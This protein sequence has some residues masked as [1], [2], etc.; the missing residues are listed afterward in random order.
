MKGVNHE[1]GV[2]ADWLDKRL[3]TTFAVFGA[4]QK[5]LATYAGMNGNLYVYE[6]K[7]V[8]S[9]GFEFEATG[10]VSDDTR[11]VLGLTKLKLTGPDGLDIYEWVPRTTVKLR[12]DTRVPA[13]P[14]LRLGVATRWQSDVYK[15]GG[16]RQ[17]AYM[18]SDAFAS[19]Q[20][21]KDLSARLN[22]NNL[23]NKKY[24]NGINNGAIYGEPRSAYISLE[25]KL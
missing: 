9:R 13:L 25:H 12:L 5:G 2:K 15:I 18:V 11:V 17:D 14:D 24:V 22:V 1:V 20:I 3:L 7:D 6:P 16:A 8:K 23:F 21:N 10:Q 19:Y 4:M